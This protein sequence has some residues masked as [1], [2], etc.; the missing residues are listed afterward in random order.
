MLQRH[1]GTQPS[2]WIQALAPVPCS[3]VCVK[4]QVVWAS[5]K[6]A[7]TAVF[8]QQPLHRFSNCF[9]IRCSCNSSL[10]RCWAGV[11]FSLRSSA[12]VAILYEYLQTKKP[13]HSTIDTG[14][15]RAICVDCMVRAYSNCLY[16][17]YILGLVSMCADAE[18]KTNGIRQVSYMSRCTRT[19]PANRAQPPTKQAAMNRVGNLVLL[20]KVQCMSVTVSIMRRCA[21]CAGHQGL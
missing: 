4:W 6:A 12:F 5:C 11:G 13:F 14:C 15:D 17:A 16:I 21:C 10:I 3:S 1:S 8:S 7:T 20:C 18:E 2:V 9:C 19:A